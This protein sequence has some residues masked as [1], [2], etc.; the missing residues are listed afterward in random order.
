MT[1]TRIALGVVALSFLPACAS[2]RGVPD[3]AADVAADAAPDAAPNAAADPAAS[4]VGA[5]AAAPVRLEPGRVLWFE[6]TSHVESTPGPAGGTGPFVTEIHVRF[7]VTAQTSDADGT[8]LTVEFD[9]VYGHVEDG[10]RLEFDTAGV[11][12]KVV[13]RLDDVYLYTPVAG[14]RLVLSVSPDGTFRTR[15]WAGSD[16]GP[17][18]PRLLAAGTWIVRGMLGDDA[19]RSATQSV[20]DAWDAHWT[21]RRDMELAAA[22]KRVVIARADESE[23]LFSSTGNTTIESQRD[24]LQAVSWSVATTLSRADGLVLVDDI[25]VGV[26]SARP[27]RDTPRS[28]RSHEVTRRIDGPGE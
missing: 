21:N 22:A 6:R 7:R 17:A 25:D 20:G 12:P 19:R 27:G 28:R 14:H 8:T 15:R 16:G 4:T 26:S 23:V 3:V 13:C 11:V 1:A 10:D 18:D 2:D 5:P 9:R 24:G